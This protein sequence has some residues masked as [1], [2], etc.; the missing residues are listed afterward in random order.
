MDKRV[1]LMALAKLC[2][3]KSHVSFSEVA[4]GLNVPEDAVEQLVIDG[5]WRLFGLCV[6][7]P[8]KC[9]QHACVRAPVCASLCASVSV[10]VSLCLYEGHRLFVF[11]LI[12]SRL[13]VCF[14]CF[15]LPL[16]ALK[17]SVIEA[18]IDDV[19]QAIT[20]TRVIYDSFEEENWDDL[21]DKLVDWQSHIVEVRKT[22]DQVKL[23]I[24]EKGA[25][26]SRSTMSQRH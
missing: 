9:I 7:L 13:F 5:E 19:K 22:L 24:A 14:V 18:T 23:Q 8:S 3:K 4:A 21:L 15:D 11:L 17:Q 12:C 26:E 6:E 1:Q 20:V 25:H 16:A 10:S 2:A